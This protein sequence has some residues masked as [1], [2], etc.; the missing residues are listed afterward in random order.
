MTR[1]CL[2]FACWVANAAV[3]AQ[4]PWLHLELLGADRPDRRNDELIGVIATLGLRGVDDATVLELGDPDTYFGRQLSIELRGPD[5]API[6]ANWSTTQQWG[7]VRLRAR[8]PAPFAASLDEAELRRLRLPPGRYTVQAKLDSSDG[9]GWRGS[10][11]SA[12]IAF[13]IHG[14][15]APQ[16][17][18]VALAGG[19]IA[20][21][22]PLLLAVTFAATAQFAARDRFGVP[23]FSGDRLPAEVTL[24]VQDGA[25]QS[26]AW[27]FEPVPPMGAGNLQNL[28]AGQQSGPRWLRLPGSA[29]TPL[30]AG[31]YAVVARL[32]LPSGATVATEPLTVRVLPHDRLGSVAQRATAVALGLADVRLQRQQVQQ[33]RSFL[34]RDERRFAEAAATLVRIR[35]L[36]IV[37]ATE[38]PSARASLLLAEVELAGGDRARAA[39]VLAAMPPLPADEPRLAVALAELQE[40]LAAVETETDRYFEPHWRAALATATGGGAAGTKVTPGQP[41]APAPG[42]VGHPVGQQPGQDVQWASGARASSVYRTAGDYSAERAVGAPR[43]ARA[44]DNGQAWCSKQADSGAEWLELDFDPPVRAK[45]VRV[46][47]SWNPGAVVLIEIVDA[48]GATTAVWRGPDATVYAPGEIGVLEAAFAEPSPLVVRVKLTLDTKL[49]KGW[50]EIDAVGLVP[51]R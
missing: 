25:G 7:V 18:L 3:L 41:S 36:A 11:Q 37:L 8:R 47:Q 30:A 31:E 39:A 51:V 17:G 27:P 45:A 42:S 13:T 15:P 29:T 49:V 26:L 24:V 33:V 20:P 23:E 46:V 4:Q 5:G 50:N 32:A 19:E 28:V 44:G 12:S 1:L 21:G 38:S 10:V 43:V 34:R 40:R 14:A 2:L 16:V 9:R 35:P 48:T 6:N 22:D